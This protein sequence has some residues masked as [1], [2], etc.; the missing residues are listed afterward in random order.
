MLLFTI[1]NSIKKYLWI[2]LILIVLYL[3][4]KWAYNRITYL[5]KENKRQVENIKN[6]DFVILTEKTKSGKLTNSINSLTV[7]ANEMQYYNTNIMKRLDDMGLKI[8]NLQSVSDITYNYTTNIDTIKS[9]KISENKYLSNWKD[10]NNTILANIN[11][12]INKNPFLSEVSFTVND[13][14][15]IAPEYTYKRKWL[16]WKKLTGVKL[17]IKSENP[18][19]K[20]EQVQTFQIIK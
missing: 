2:A 9:E 17:H 11:T 14:L 10:N 13:T 3:A 4:S 15:L 19:F 12:P 7:K 6:K 16:F 1:W 18:N 5:E 20:L 8:K